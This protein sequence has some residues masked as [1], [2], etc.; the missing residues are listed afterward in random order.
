LIKNNL[1]KSVISLFL[2]SY[3]IVVLASLDK[4]QKIARDKG[5][6]LYH[7][8]MRMAA[9]PYLTVAAKAGDEQA[10]YYLGEALRLD[11]M[12]MTEES[13]KWYGEAAKQG[14]LFAM[15]RLGSNQD[16]CNY[17]KVCPDNA[18][19]WREKAIKLANEQASKGNPTAMRVLYNA[20]KGL[21]WLEKAAENNDPYAKYLLAN[22][23]KSGEG[24]FF[25][26]GS[27]RETILKL[28]KD[29]SKD[30]YP[31]AMFEYYLKIKSQNMPEALE[32]LE[33]SANMGYVNAVV[34]LSANLG[35][36]SEHENVPIDTIKAAALMKLAVELSPEDHILVD[37]LKEIEGK[38]TPEQLQNSKKFAADWK[39]SHPDLSYFVPVYGF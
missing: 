37:M 14:N 1:L 39:K 34:E 4:E 9:I 25:L 13:A 28:L 11:N 3:S 27:R 24:W 15:L 35:G 7:Q 20:G 33:R 32:W 30:G 10:Q 19:S 6:T 31:P 12:Y 36:I 26:P 17:L 16:A 23:Y 22:F 5:L 21:S 29:S 38:L 8:H 2:L 18:Y